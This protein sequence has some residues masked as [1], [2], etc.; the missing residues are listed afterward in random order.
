MNKIYH[1]KSAPLHTFFLEI[2]ILQQIKIKLN[3]TKHKNGVYLGNPNLN[4][5]YS[6]SLKL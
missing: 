1:Y 2:Y 5:R 3:N 6:S 4:Y